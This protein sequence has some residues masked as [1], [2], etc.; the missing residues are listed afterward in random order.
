MERGEGEDREKENTE[1]VKEKQKKEKGGKG[2][3]KMNNFRNII[4][5]KTHAQ[6]R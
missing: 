2:D 5:L 4:T 1:V 3:K 6:L